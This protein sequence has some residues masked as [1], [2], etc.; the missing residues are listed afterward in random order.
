MARKAAGYIG[1]QALACMGRDVELDVVQQ[2]HCLV[3]H[4]GV[5][6]QC[7]PREGKRAQA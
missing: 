7:D 3:G 6:L 4:G 5:R 1:E 2:G